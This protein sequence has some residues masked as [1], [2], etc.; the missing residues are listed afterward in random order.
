MLAHSQIAGLAWER[1]RGGL[2]YKQKGDSEAVFLGKR[3]PIVMKI[4]G[5]YTDLT[6]STQ[7]S[8]CFYAHNPVHNHFRVNLLAEK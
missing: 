2:S 4:P 3:E 1:T 8:S 5:K 6:R 7:L